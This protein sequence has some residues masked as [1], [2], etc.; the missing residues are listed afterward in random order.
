MFAPLLRILAVAALCLGAGSAAAE[1]PRGQRDLSMRITAH[2]VRKCAVGTTAIDF[3]QGGVPIAREGGGEAIGTLAFECSKGIRAELTPRWRSE[4]ERRQTTPVGERRDV[5][6]IRAFPGSAKNAPVERRHAVADLRFSGACGRCRAAGS[7]R[8]GLPE[9]GGAGLLTPATLVARLL[10][11]VLVDGSGLSD[12]A[13][14]SY[15]GRH[16]A[17]SPERSSD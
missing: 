4:S 12:V 11:T 10:S 13:G 8:P 7:Q 15:A 17:A 14:W 5:H 9:A 6:R 16:I 1:P 2:V 3:G